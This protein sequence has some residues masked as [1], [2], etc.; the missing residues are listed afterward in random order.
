V[1]LEAI[2]ALRSAT[3]DLPA[4]ARIPLDLGFVLAQVNRMEE[5]VTAFRE[6]VRRQPDFAAAHSN[7]AN[8]LQALGRVDEAVIS[9]RQAIRINP[10]AAEAHHTLGNFLRAAGRIDGAMA[11]YARAIEIAPQYLEAYDNYLYSMCFSPAHDAQTTVA[12]HRRWGDRISTGVPTPG[13]HPNDRNPQRPLRIGYVSGDFYEHIAGIWIQE[14]LSH[15]DRSQ[16]QVICYSATL[17]ETAATERFKQ[18][19]GP[20][21]WRSIAGLTD[22]Q[23]AELIRRD[24]IDILVDCALHSGGNR[25]PLFAHKPAPV[26]VTHIGYPGTTGLRQ[27][28]YR[29]TDAELDPPGRPQPFGTEQPYR[30]PGGFFLYTQTAPP[31]P[32]GPLPALSAPGG[33]ITFGCLNNPVKVTEPAVELFARVL[34]RVPGSRLLLMQRDIATLRNER[35]AQFAAHGVQPDRIEFVAPGPLRHFRI[36]HQAVDIG[37]DPIPCNGGI[38]SCD[39]LLMGVPIVSLS[40]DTPS[41]R[42]GASLLARVGLRHLA[43]EDQDAYIQTTARLAAD[44]AALAQLRAELPQRTLASTIFN[45][46]NHTRELEAA[47]REMWRKWCATST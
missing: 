44:T 38:T 41:A 7:L 46:A 18:L 20:G 2:E 4:D 1:P 11:A 29:V 23:A 10:G 17:S 40:G 24:A 28:D 3:A 37:L 12:Q 31:P 16:V 19:A 43:V 34:Q 25:L 33:V 26:Q 6:A 15:H 30:L 36:A 27:I 47:Y 8:A 39:A 45:S 42:A 21:N 32:P 22:R 13:P 14:L 35:R 9:V 5:A